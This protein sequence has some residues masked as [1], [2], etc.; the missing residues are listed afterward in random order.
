MPAIYLIVGCHKHARAW[1]IAY[2]AGLRSRIGDLAM[3]VNVGEGSHEEREDKF[4]PSEES[5]NKYEA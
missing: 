5:P 4:F 1:L 3:G 2:F